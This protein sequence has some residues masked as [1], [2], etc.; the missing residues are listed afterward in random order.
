[1]LPLTTM[2]SLPAIA[3]MPPQASLPIS[4]PGEVPFV[5]DS[6]I[7]EAQKTSPRTGRPNRTRD[8]TNL[9]RRVLIVDDEAVILFGFKKVL[10]GNGVEVDTAETLQE[11]V[12]LLETRDYRCVITDLKLSGS[13]ND[14]GFEIM[15]RVKG[16]KPETKIIM[17]TGYGSPEVMEKALSEGASY[18]YE[19]PVSATIL[20][21]ALKRLGL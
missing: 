3:L 15:Q 7:G 13:S 1:M 21:D 14:D 10:Q 2:K 20:R 6:T 19:K 18:Y 4:P 12:D 11:A 5:Q 9:G 17:I 16:R 8:D